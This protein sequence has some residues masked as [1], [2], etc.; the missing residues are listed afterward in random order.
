MAKRSWIGFAVVGASMVEEPIEADRVRVL[1]APVP[2]GS[3]GRAY[4]E[5]ALV[6]G[7]TV[8]IRSHPAGLLVL[9]RADNVVQLKLRRE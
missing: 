2:P 3:N 7:D 4:L 5:V 1:L 6:D 8:E 9:P